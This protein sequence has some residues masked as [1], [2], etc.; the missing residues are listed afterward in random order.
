MIIDFF[1]NLREKG[2][3]FVETRGF[4]PRFAGWEFRVQS[5]NQ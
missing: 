2:K 4:E 3:K 1:A 5:A